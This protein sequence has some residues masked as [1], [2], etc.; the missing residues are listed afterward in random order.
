[1]L[2]T[3]LQYNE[4]LYIFYT[5]KISDASNIY[6]G[7]SQVSKIYSGSTQIWPTI[8][9]VPPQITLTGPR[10]SSAWFKFTYTSDKSIQITSFT[11][12]TN[13]EFALYD[14]TQDSP[15]ETDILSQNDRIYR[16][17]DDLHITNT[18][19][20][21]FTLNYICDGQAGSM[22]F[23][24]YY[25]SGMTITQLSDSYNITNKSSGDVIISLNTSNVNIWDRDSTFNSPI[26]QLGDDASHTHRGDTTEIKWTIRTTPTYMTL[27]EQ[28]RAGQTVDWNNIRSTYNGA[29]TLTLSNIESAIGGTI[30]EGQTYYLYFCLQDTWWADEGGNPTAQYFYTNYPVTFYTVSLGETITPSEF[31]I[32]N[33]ITANQQLPNGTYPLSS[34]G[35]YNLIHDNNGSIASFG[36]YAD[37]RIYKTLGFF[38]ISS[39]DG[40]LITNI[41]FNTTTSAYTPDDL[42]SDTGTLTTDATNK[43]ITWTGSATSVTF[44]RIGNTTSQIRAKSIEIS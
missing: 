5:M 43:Q 9:I 17:K 6:L 18:A 12:M 21:E 41:I 37:F 3:H 4:Q 13:I 32:T 10:R 2:L 34:T 42:Q 19:H 23:L 29:Y 38:T 35:K 26:I 33:N 16:L 40:S 36:I 11:N 20:Y 28:A 8:P 7:S 31:K 27:D 30:V 22:T 1:M 39:T 14:Y 25:H 44:T 15:D 24:D